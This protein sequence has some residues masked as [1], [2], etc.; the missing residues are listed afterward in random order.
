MKQLFT[1]FI[2]LFWVFLQTALGQVVSDDN[3]IVAAQ[4][5]SSASSFTIDNFTVPLGNNVAL[6]IASRTG[7]VETISNINFNG[8]DYSTQN[9]GTG[10]I[11]NINS[12]IWAIP[13]GNVETPISNQTITISLSGSSAR[14]GAFAATFKNVNQTTPANNFISEIDGDLSIDITSSASNMVFDIIGSASTPNFSANGSQII[15]INNAPVN[16]NGANKISGSYKLSSNTLE[17]MSWSNSGGSNNVIHLGVNIQWDVVGLPVEMTNFRAV[18]VNEK[19]ELIWA[20]ASELDND[21][22]EIEESQGG[23]E[24]KKIGEVKGNGITT[25]EKNYLFKVDNPNNGISYF[26]LK[27]IDFDGGYEYSKVISINFKWESREVGEFYPNP[28]NLGMVNL[29]Y[30]SQKDAEIKVSVFDMAGKLAINQLR[31]VSVGSNN[32][33]FDFS[34]LNKGIYFV[35]IGGEINPTYRK[36]IIEK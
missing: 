36:L 13:L 18:Q 31:Q 21:K 27:Q 35:R 7:D 22:F 16:P 1:I 24:F 3:A 26:R 34:G 4:P 23:Q 2:F 20:T 15:L 8:V 10:S 12:E 32:L 30:S 11:G 6:L 5:S 14:L 29:D 19:V 33:A 28:S 9:V 25:D 17:T